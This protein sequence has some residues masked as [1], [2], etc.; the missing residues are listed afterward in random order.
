MGWTLPTPATSQLLLGL[1]LIIYFN[2]YLKCS[3]S[4]QGDLT[5]WSAFSILAYNF[6]LITGFPVSQS[7]T[8]ALALYVSFH[9]WH[10]SPCLIVF[11]RR[12]PC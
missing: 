4:E 11:P 2:I 1:K 8:R 6:S 7:C 5:F 9:S 12:V 10:L 3:N